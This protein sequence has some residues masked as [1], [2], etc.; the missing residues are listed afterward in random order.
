MF[1]GSVF[2]QLLQKAQS[3]TP[4]DLFSANNYYS[5][6][7]LF[8]H[9]QPA[10]PTEVPS[11]NG[12]VAVVIMNQLKTPLLAVDWLQD[13]R[14][15]TDPYM[16][17]LLP[18]SHMASYPATIDPDTQTPVK[19]HQIPGMRRYPNPSRHGDGDRLGAIGLYRFWTDRPGDLHGGLAFST[20]EDGSGP[21]IGVAFSLA[22]GLCAVSADVSEFGCGATDP[23][24]LLA[25]RQTAIENNLSVL[26]AAAR[27]SASKGKIHVGARWSYNT[28]GLEPNT[29]P[30]FVWVREV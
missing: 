7:V 29:K 1:F 14:T 15:D 8:Q 6:L 11:T 20:K 12:G 18:N 2:W 13:I 30:L 28:Y 19:K 4:A 26:T 3:S 16:F 27:G 9:H 24:D 5:P 23:G 10:S 25:P 17:T 22:T 21:W